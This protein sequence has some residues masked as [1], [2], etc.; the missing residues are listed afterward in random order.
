MLCSKKRLGESKINIILNEQN[1]VEDLLNQPA[2]SKKTYQDLSLI[3]K[4]L[5]HNKALKADQIYTELVNIM[6]DKYPNFIISKWQN[7]LLK[8]SRDAN[9]KNLFVIDYIPVTQNELDT[10]N[11][12]YS[13]PIKRVAFAILC[14]AKYKN[15]VNPDNN[16]WINYEFKDIFR[17]S[18]VTATVKEQCNI[19][20]EMKNSG[21]VKMNNLVNN[22]SL[23]ISYIDQSDSNTILKIYDFRNLGYEYL[24]YCGDKFIRCDRCNILTRKRGKTDKYCKSCSIISEKE[25]TNSRVKKHRE[26]CN[27]S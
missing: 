22:L 26:K 23:N 6:E 9:K 12:I 5:Y 11:S 1:Y 4:Y 2:L 20:N 14:L 17:V 21:L 15:A 19:I 8:I 10:I 16:N 25:K 13:K 27:V 18:N 24:L 7:S 3:A